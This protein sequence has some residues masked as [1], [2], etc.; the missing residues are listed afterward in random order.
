M[1]GK[2]QI[3]ERIGAGGMGTVYKAVH[4]SLGALRAIK[5]MRRELVEDGYVE[6]AYN[7]EIEQ[8][9][10]YRLTATL[11]HRQ[12]STSVHKSAHVFSLKLLRAWSCRAWRA[13]S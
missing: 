5:V 6:K 9:D 12:L 10:T 3:D 7:V 4:V 8:G 13:E 2:H 1:D 11:E